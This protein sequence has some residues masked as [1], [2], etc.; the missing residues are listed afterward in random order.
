MKKKIE[1]YLREK[2]PGM[3][4]CD[5]RG[6][7]LVGNDFEGCLHATQ[8]S[9]FPSNKDSSSC[10]NMG[11]SSLPFLGQP[12]A[13]YATPMHPY[14]AKRQFEMMNGAMY[15][16]IKYSNKRICSESPKASKGDLEALHRFFQ[17]LRGGYINGI[18]QSAL[19]RRR[20]AEKTASDGNI[21]A[22]NSLNLSKE[23]RERLP[24]FFRNRLSNSYRDHQFETGPTSAMPY[25]YMQWSQPSPMGNAMPGPA[26]LSSL[27]PSPLSRSK[28]FE[29]RTRKE[30]NITPIAQLRLASYTYTFCSFSS[31][32]HTQP[33]QRLLAPVL[34][35]S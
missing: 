12:L 1:K 11:H 7:F 6:I 17:T 14:A 15:S 28:E 30:T 31:D 25:G 13:P 18:Y 27:K 16:G 32:V 23:E 5:E 26:M 34:L 33:I 19:E 4:V 20:L 2:H 35:R 24:R 22:L 21:E 29:P 8:Q 9:S 10:L 3:P